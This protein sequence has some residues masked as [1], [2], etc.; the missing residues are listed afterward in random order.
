MG[1]V[2]D[3]G[4]R[5]D[6]EHKYQVLTGGPEVTLVAM[7]GCVVEKPG[8]QLCWLQ[9][10]GGYENDYKINQPGTKAHLAWLKTVGEEKLGKT[11]V[12]RLLNQHEEERNKFLI[13]DTREKTYFPAGGL[14]QDSVLV[15]RTAA[16]REFEQNVADLDGINTKGT[17]ENIIKP[18]ATNERYTLLTII[19]ALCGSSAIPYQERGAAAKIARLTEEIGVAVSDDAIGRALK[20]IPDALE[21]RSK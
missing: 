10:D 20:K 6:V 14:S 5:L 8:G 21:A 11:E 15:V 7:D 3:W 2:H 13:G 4:E 16:L 1:F 12:E 19:A 9:E 18:L 17:E